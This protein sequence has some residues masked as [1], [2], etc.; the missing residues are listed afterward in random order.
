VL[1][2]MQLNFLKIIQK[3]GCFPDVVD[4]NI[5]YEQTAEWVEDYCFFEIKTISYKLNQQG[6]ALL[7]NDL[8]LK[9]VK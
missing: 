6:I 9:E 8:K 5:D 7:N 1:T 3:D 2:E 4:V